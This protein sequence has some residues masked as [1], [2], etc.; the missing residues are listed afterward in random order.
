MGF[1]SWK[2]KCNAK[3]CDCTEKGFNQSSAAVA[4]LDGCIFISDLLLLATDY[5]LIIG[6]HERKTIS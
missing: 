6:T 3:P 4:A 1:E 5:K 2:N